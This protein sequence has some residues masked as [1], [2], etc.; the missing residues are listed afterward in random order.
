MVPRYFFLKLPSKIK[1]EKDW[2][3]SNV[4][5]KT[6]KSNSLDLY[7][8]TKEKEEGKRFRLYYKSK[9]G[10]LK[11]HFLDRNRTFTSSFSSLPFCVGTTQDNLNCSIV[12]PHVTR[13][14]LPFKLP[15]L[16]FIQLSVPPAYPSCNPI[17]PHLN[18]TN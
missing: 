18:P 16:P 8:L 1:G 9:Q 11:N 13:P 15:L 5:Q 2:E 4:L 12:R 17:M 10:N 6:I 14:S 3:Q 7:S